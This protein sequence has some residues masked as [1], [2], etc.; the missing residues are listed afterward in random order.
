MKN[1]QNDH[2]TR[3]VFIKSTAMT[4]AGLTL[5]STARAREIFEQ[6]VPTADHFKAELVRIIEL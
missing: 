6:A 1:K 4:V 3:R 2:V 5:V